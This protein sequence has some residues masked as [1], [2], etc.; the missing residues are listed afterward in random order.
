MVSTP[1]G[2]A[3]LTERE[4]EV[5]ALVASGLTNAEIG[6]ALH[7]SHWTVKRHVAR[8]MR[9]LGLRRRVDLAVWYERRDEGGT[10]RALAKVGP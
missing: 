4:G 5:V 2:E 1:P 9:K 3:Q 8:I 7:L 6:D 10:S